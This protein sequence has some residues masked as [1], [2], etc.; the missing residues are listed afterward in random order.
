MNRVAEKKIAWLIDER[1]GVII[2]DT[3][4]KVEVQVGDS[5]ATVD[6]WGKVTWR[7]INSSL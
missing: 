4:E 7:D 2:S 5:I 1:E 6:E 3:P